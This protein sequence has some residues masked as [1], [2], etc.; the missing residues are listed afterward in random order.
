MSSLRER[1]HATYLVPEAKVDVVVEKQKGENDNARPRNTFEATI[2]R[3]RTESTK[4]RTEH[5]Q[6]RKDLV[7]LE[8]DIRQIWEELEGM[9]VNTKESA[10]LVAECVELQNEYDELTKK[11]ERLT[12]EIDKLQVEYEPFQAVQEGI[13]SMHTSSAEAVQLRQQ[14]QALAEEAERIRE[15]W[16][17]HEAYTA[18]E[19]ARIE[20]EE[21]FIAAGQRDA[22]EKLQPV[23]DQRDSFFLHRGAVQDP[24][25]VH[26]PEYQQWAQYFQ[27][28]DAFVSSKEGEIASLAAQ[29]EALQKQRQFLKTT[30]KQ[31]L[32]RHDACME[33]RLDVLEKISAAEVDWKAAEGQYEKGKIGAGVVMEK[34]GTFSTK[35]QP[36][37]I[38]RTPPP[39]TEEDS[40]KQAA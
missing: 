35:D 9:G 17:A 33:E 19:E 26:V 11:V 40:F 30:G 13:K 23:K 37:W 1:T 39:A 4:V 34:Y 38:S 22:F 20:R 6:A 24:R 31:I 10:P 32:T 2:E 28:A 14:E 27:E 36:A 21:E 18:Q 12:N 25:Y 7:V 16:A 3:I 15:E 5:Q 8:N 29:R